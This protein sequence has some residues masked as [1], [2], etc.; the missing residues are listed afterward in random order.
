M[1]NTQTAEFFASEI[2]E[3]IFGDFRYSHTHFCSLESFCFESC[4]KEK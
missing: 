4:N 2:I 1:Q 3:H